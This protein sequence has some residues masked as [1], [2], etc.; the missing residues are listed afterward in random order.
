M[1]D[2]FPGHLLIH[3]ENIDNSLKRTKIIIEQFN[4]EKIYV[5]CGKDVNHNY[6]DLQCIT[7]V[8]YLEYDILDETLFETCYNAYGRIKSKSKLKTKIEYILN[9]NDFF[10]NID[11]IILII[12]S[13]NDLIN[14]EK[15][16]YY[17]IK[18][19]Y[20][21]YGYIKTIYLNKHSKVYGKLPPNSIS[22][23][24][25]TMLEVTES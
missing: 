8:E 19:I 24:F 9:D 13:R 4:P 12:D 15:M 5:I 6:N 25:N 2:V 10:Q 21:N 20:S 7:K 11:N 17:D 22:F 3:G 18:S 23:Y 16:L 1:E 14:D